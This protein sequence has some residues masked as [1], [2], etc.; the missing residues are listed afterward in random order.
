M[1]TKAALGVCINS[2]TRLCALKYT[3]IRP[4]HQTWSHAS[5]WLLTNS[6]EN[7]MWI[8]DN[9]KKA[10]KKWVRITQAHAV[11]SIYFGPFATGVGCV[12]V[13]SEFGSVTKTIHETMSHDQGPLTALTGQGIKSSERAPIPYIQW[14]EDQILG[15]PICLGQGVTHPFVPTC[16]L[17]GHDTESQFWILKQK[18]VGSITLNIY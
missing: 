14:N 12:Y 10:T 15:P 8:L 6:R 3:T 7:C 9:E 17:P 16:K 2:R 18:K 1:N 13:S 4:H 11:W 5:Y